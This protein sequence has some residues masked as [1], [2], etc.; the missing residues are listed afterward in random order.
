MN[1]MSGSFMLTVDEAKVWLLIGAVVLT[2]FVGLGIYLIYAIES[3]SH[4]D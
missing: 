1:A 4:K 2:G 3:L